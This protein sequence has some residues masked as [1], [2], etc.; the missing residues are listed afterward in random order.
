MRL[1]E[2]KITLSSKPLKLNVVLTT[3]CNLNCL[4]CEVRRIP[5]QIPEKVIGEVISL[6]PYLREII[7][8]GGEVFLLDYF[9]GLLERATPYPDLTHDITTNGHL[10]DEEWMSMLNKINLNLNISIDGV[11]KQTYEYIRKGSKFEDLI[12]TLELINETK[13]QGEGK[14]LVLVMIVTVMHSNYRELEKV[15]EFAKRFKFDRIILQPIKVILITE[16]TFSLIM[17]RRYC[18]ILMGLNSK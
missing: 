17:K 7:W 3:R 10:I 9:K 1:K 4:M 14:R 5:W 16:K 2:R 18:D 15:I 8:Q 11:T 12:R 6:F 13:N